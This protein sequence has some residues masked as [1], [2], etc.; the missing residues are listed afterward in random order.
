[1]K[2]EIRIKRICK[3]LRP[4]SSMSEQ[5]YLCARTGYCEYQAAVNR[6]VNPVSYVLCKKYNAKDKGLFRK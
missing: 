1:M 6:L 4:F 2:L 5:P 3:D